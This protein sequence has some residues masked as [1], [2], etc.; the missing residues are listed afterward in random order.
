MH[1]CIS[2]VFLKRMTGAFRALSQGI[3]I[4]RRCLLTV[5]C[6]LQPKPTQHLLYISSLHLP[7]ILAMP[8]D[9]NEILCSP[10][11]I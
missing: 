10:T 8:H 7:I 9:H 2:L 6:S 3:T 5:P 11:K 1:A 4:F